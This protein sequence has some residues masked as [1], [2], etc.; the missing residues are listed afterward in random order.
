MHSPLI[1]ALALLASADS[2]LGQQA[3]VL[4]THSSSFPGGA[5]GHSAGAL[6]DVDRDG[7]TDYVV[8]VP[9]HDPGSRPKGGSVLVFS[10]RTGKALRHFKGLGANDLLGEAVAGCG[11]INS[12]G[13][14]DILVG[15]PETLH[16][17]AGY[18]RVYSGKDGTVLR[19]YTGLSPNDGFGSGVAGIGDVTSDGVVDFAVLAPRGGTGSGGYVV[20]YDGRQNKVVGTHPYQW[21]GTP[22]DVRGLG[23]IDNDGFPDWGVGSHGGN[24]VNC[25]IY[26]G[27]LNT[28]MKAISGAGVSLCGLGDLNGD[29]YGEVALGSPLRRGNVGDVDIL[30]GKDYSLIRRLSGSLAGDNFGMLVRRG[31][32]TTGDGKAEII[33]GK[34]SRGT[35]VLSAVDGRGLFWQKPAASYGKSAVGVGDINGDGAL[36][37]LVGNSPETGA[38]GVARVISGAMPDLRVES[39]VMSKVSANPGETVRMTVQLRND[40]KVACPP[41]RLRLLL[42]LDSLPSSGDSQLGDLSLGSLAAGATKTTYLDFIVPSI[43][44][45]PYYALAV[46]DHSNL[47]NEMRE[48]NNLRATDFSMPTADLTADSIGSHVTLTAAGSALPVTLRIGNIGDSAAPASTTRIYLSN[49]SAVSAGDALLAS[50]PSS[51]ISASTGLS[52]RTVLTIPAGISGSKY[53]LVKVDA[54]GAVHELSEQNNLCS[55]PIAVGTGAADL[56]IRKLIHTSMRRSASFTAYAEIENIGSMPSGPTDLSLALHGGIRETLP[57]ASVPALDPGQ[58]TIVSSKMTLSAGAHYHS[59]LRADVDASHAVAELSESNNSFVKSISHAA[60]TGL[61]S[62]RAR[63]FEVDRTEPEPGGA[64]VVHA[65]GYNSYP[66]SGMAS[67]T[68][69]ISGHTI[70]YV[71]S[72]VEGRA[73]ASV[74]SQLTIPCDLRPGAYPL[75]CRTQTGSL[76]ESIVVRPRSSRD[77]RLEWERESSRERAS[78]YASR[79]AVKYLRFSSPDH[80]AHYALTNWTQ[81]TDLGPDLLYQIGL[82]MLNSSTLRGWLVLTDSSG[83]ASPSLNLPVLPIGTPLDVYIRTEVYRQNL[84][85][86]TTS[87]GVKL[88]I[89]L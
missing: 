82:S 84:T 77:A 7:T 65:S 51:S 76:W 74:T 18:A 16:Q 64:V 68:F 54:T 21:G 28:A 71:S 36:D 13:H 2:L 72:H 14:A 43:P 55:L 57:L 63:S 9:A 69:R 49:D 80:P 47:V 87:S 37:Y 81:R 30:S 48:D 78:A 59:Q 60:S 11:D 23:D 32:D 8:G 12:D 19:H 40:G 25:A 83:A 17:G 29:G 20:I 61:V 6:A 44:T 5:L 85:K 26:S 50:I 86:V 24:V 45:G 15:A 10:G 67:F 70:G 46:A 35:F 66:Y 31:H 75:E 4:R 33:V 27:R 56:V 62:V 22:S 34:K 58:S 1:L 88:R 89:H 73:F 41:S 79:S 53:L 52:W 38:S 42:S 39:V 3:V